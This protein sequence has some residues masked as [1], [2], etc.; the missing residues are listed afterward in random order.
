MSSKM[1]IKSAMQC[2]I[3]EFMKKESSEIT[4]VILARG[5]PY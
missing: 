1:M 5:N 4:P 2:K 3:L